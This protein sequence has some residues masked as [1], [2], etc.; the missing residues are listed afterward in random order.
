M[1]EPT[2]PIQLPHVVVVLARC[3]H[4]HLTFGIRIEE[5]APAQWSA[6]WAFRISERQAGKEGYDHSAIRGAFEIDDAYPGCPH[7][8]N[9]GFFRCRCGK[10]GCWDLTTRQVTCPWCNGKVLLGGSITNLEAGSDR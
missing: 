1:N 8:P 5:K 2:S 6:D 10:V 9:T 7:C 3:C 4:T